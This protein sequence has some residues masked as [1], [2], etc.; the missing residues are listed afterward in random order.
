LTGREP[1]LRTSFAVGCSRD[2][3]NPAIALNYGD[4]L[5][6]P[7]LFHGP[8]TLTDLRFDASLTEVNL[9]T[10]RIRITFNNAIFDT[11]Q[12]L[13]HIPTLPNIIRSLS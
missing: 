11:H 5:S 3:T 8:E 4:S 7:Q 13:S 9:C 2:P 10:S 6:F 12:S 1:D